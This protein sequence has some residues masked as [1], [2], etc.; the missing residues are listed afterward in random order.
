MALNHLHHQAGDLGFELFVLVQHHLRALPVQLF[1]GRLVG[2]L[3]RR[4]QKLLQQP[5][6]LICR[7]SGKV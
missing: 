6:L 4:A 2:L 1:D 5:V 7:V 3:D